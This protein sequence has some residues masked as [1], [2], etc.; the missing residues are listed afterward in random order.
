MEFK[1]LAERRP[2]NLEIVR[3]ILEETPGAFPVELEHI[4]SAAYLS[5]DRKSGGRVERLCISVPWAWLEESAGGPRLAEAVR[6]FAE[7]V[8]GMGAHPFSQSAAFA[9]A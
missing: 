4:G 6:R 8:S 7:S 3:A 9:Q 2:R 5:A 1:L